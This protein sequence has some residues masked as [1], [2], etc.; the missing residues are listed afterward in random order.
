M[1]HYTYALSSAKAT[2]SGA[3]RV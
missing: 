1:L 3:L 2:D